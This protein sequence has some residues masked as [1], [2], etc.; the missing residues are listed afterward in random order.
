MWRLVERRGVSRLY[1]DIVDAGTNVEAG[2]WDDGLAVIKVRGVA[3][4]DGPGNGCAEC[5]QKAGA[6][7]PGE[8]TGEFQDAQDRL[9]AQ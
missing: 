4:L 6:E 1:N 7:R 8:T 9:I 5:A 3:R 2:Q